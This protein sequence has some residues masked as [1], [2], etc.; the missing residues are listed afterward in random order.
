MGYIN[1]YVGEKNL[2]LNDKIKLM[3][4]FAKITK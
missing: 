3:V 1:V 2:S 4:N